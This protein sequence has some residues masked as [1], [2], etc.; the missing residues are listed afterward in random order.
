MLKAVNYKCMSMLSRDQTGAGDRF[1]PQGQW[2][3]Q[4]W[5]PRIKPLGPKGECLSSHF[6]V[7]AEWCALSGKRAIRMSRIHRC[8]SL[9]GCFGITSFLFISM[10][11]ILLNYQ[12]KG[13]QNEINPGFWI[14]T[15][16]LKGQK[17]SHF[18]DVALTRKA[19]FNSQYLFEQSL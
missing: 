17:F 1:Q 6:H 2:C 12:A 8:M 16:F 10:Q 13:E 9:C 5:N 15:W 3:S 7:S 19:W 14:C 18:V 11:L 4:Y